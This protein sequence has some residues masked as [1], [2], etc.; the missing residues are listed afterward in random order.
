MGARGPIYEL[1]EGISQDSL[2]QAEQL[3]AI[4]E[5]EALRKL[6]TIDKLERKTK[7]KNHLD[8]QQLSNSFK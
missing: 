2:T 4:A 8:M 3:Q 1:V 7:L 6:D 5:Y